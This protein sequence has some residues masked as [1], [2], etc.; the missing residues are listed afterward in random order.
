MKTECISGFDDIAFR[1]FDD[2][3]PLSVYPK[4]NLPL[5]VYPKANKLLSAPYLCICFVY[6]AKCVPSTSR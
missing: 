4:A 3:I 1:L 2:K 5:F 6:D